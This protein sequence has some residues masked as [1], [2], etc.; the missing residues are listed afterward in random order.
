M[1]GA[2]G[3]TLS[4]APTDSASQWILL[5]ASF[6]TGITAIVIALI[7]RDRKMA[8]P[9]RRRKRK[10]QPGKPRRKRS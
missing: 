3:Q 2:A 1:L 6:V 9:Q 4:S 8:L 10:P 7:N 5:L